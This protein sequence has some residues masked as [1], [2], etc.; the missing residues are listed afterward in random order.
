MTLQQINYALTVAKMGSM[1]KA[2]ETLFVS[3]P[4]LTTAIK[5][6]EKETGITIFLRTSK[7]VVQTNEGTC[8]LYT[9]DAA[10]D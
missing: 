3:Q 5:E 6:L 4:S 7:G 2:A 10:D 8:L 1:N 9:S